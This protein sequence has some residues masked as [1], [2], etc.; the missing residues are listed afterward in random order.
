MGRLRPAGFFQEL[1]HG[2]GAGPSLRA[3]VSDRAQE[4]EGA[5]VRYLRSGVLLIGCPG[6]A[7]DL[8]DHSAGFVGSPHILTD[9]VW[10]WPGDLAYY[11]EKYHVSLPAEF[12]DHIQ[13]NNWRVLD[14][15]DIDIASLEL[16]I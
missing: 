6:V 9:G 3:L 8:L 4:H 15:A 5:V 10:A 12:T 2:S 16:E 14:Q 7:T 13:A 11:V 1:P